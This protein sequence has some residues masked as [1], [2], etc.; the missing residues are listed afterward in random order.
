M[1]RGHHGRITGR[2][3]LARFGELI[4][5]KTKKRLT[6]PPPVIN[7]SRVLFYSLMP[8]TVRYSGKISIH[9]GGKELGKVPRL[10]IAEPLREKGFRVFHCNRNWNLFSMDSLYKS[11]KDAKKHAELMYP[12]VSST[13]IKTSVSKRKA[14][15]IE[16]EICSGHECSFCGRIPVE[17]DMS[18]HG[19]K[20]VICNICVNEI[21]YDFLK[22]EQQESARR[23]RGDYYPENGFNHIESYISRLL[24]STNTHRYVA[25]FALDG[26]RGCGLFVDGPAL[27]VS[28]IMH[29]QQDAT[30]EK[31]I[32]KFFNSRGATPSK[33]YL[34]QDGRARILQYP[35][36]GNAK[37][38]TAITKAILQELC[39]VRPTEAM[40]IN[41]REK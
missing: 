19:K 30:R 35:L 8:R 15:A 11:I 16:R 29:S 5:K 18:T 7:S 40:S 22:L 25:F 34:A 23:P 37:K 26:R 9:I 28:F 27:Q 2:G 4:V 41:Y 39:A 33:D 38:L 24:D 20:A 21:Y 31:K 17:F 32:R 12:G 14:K 36:K 10:V 3:P 1:E 6:K 13:W